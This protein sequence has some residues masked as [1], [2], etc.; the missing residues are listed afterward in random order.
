MSS[1]CALC[2][3]SLYVKEWFKLICPIFI[4]S[5]LKVPNTHDNYS[6]DKNKKNE[7]GWSHSTYGEDAFMVL[8]GKP[9]GRRPLGRP[10]R[11]R[12]DNIKIGLQEVGWG[13]W[14]GLTLWMGSTKCRGEFLTSLEPV[15]FS[16]RTL[17]HGS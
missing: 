1:L 10:R 3:P 2:L 11:R 4:S 7:M 9:E 17:L 14:T 6:G 13:T 16:G 8:V 12:K 5:L 15:S